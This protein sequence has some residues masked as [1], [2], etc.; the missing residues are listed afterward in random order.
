AAL[1][2]V[3]LRVEP[4]ETVA[5]V[6]RSGAGKSTL[7]K[8][9]LRFYD[10]SAGTVRLDDNDLRDV[11]LASLR[12]N[13]ALLL[14]ENLVFDGTI[15]ENIAYGREGASRNDV[16]QAARDAD[17]HTFISSLPDGYETA[18]GERGQRLSGGQRQRIAIARA[19]IRD[20]PVL[21]LDEPTTGLDAESADRILGPLQRLMRNRTTIVITHNLLTVR[22]G[23][24]VVVLEDGRLVDDGTHGELLSRGAPIPVAGLALATGP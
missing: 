8:L 11:S 5:L 24:R 14:Q 2:D 17:A 9:L 12:A 7:A 16:E 15:Y 21:I 13:I 20:A 22:P 19:M 10:P 4:G 1:S 3:S 6:G 23:T 18:I